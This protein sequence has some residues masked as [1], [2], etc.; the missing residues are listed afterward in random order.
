MCDTLLNIKLLFTLI[1]NPNTHIV[2]S[3]LSLHHKF[4]NGVSFVKRFKRSHKR[5]Y[6]NDVPLLLVC[7]EGVIVGGSFFL[8]IETYSK[9]NAKSHILS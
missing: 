4:I 8:R 2:S 1:M 3:I 5:V 6:H 7:L 9:E